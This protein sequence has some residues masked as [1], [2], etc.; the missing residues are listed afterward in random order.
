MARAALA[1]LASSA[2]LV[3]TDAVELT[4][5][6]WDRDTAGKVVFAKFF[7]TWCGHCKQMKPDW[8]KLMAEFKDS[9][10]ILVADVDCTGDGKSMCDKIGVK[11]YPTIKFGDPDKLEDYVGGRTFEELK[12]HAETLKPKCGASRMELCSESQKRQIADFSALPAAEREKIISNKGEAIEK[13]EAD[14]KE[15]VDN[16]SKRYQEESDM[17]TG[18]INAIND[19]GLSL[20]KRVHE[21]EKRTS[22][23]L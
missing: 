1:L 12:E 21:Y 15:F 8:D 18:K 6:T 4:K 16:L 3:P 14:F 5:E 11:G 10:S 19:K 9:E 20:L 13:I 2:L 23:E 7:A 17:K 22:G